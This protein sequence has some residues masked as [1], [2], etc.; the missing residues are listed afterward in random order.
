MELFADTLLK[1]VPSKTRLLCIVQSNYQVVEWFHPQSALST[2]L[3]EHCL[4]C[5]I[6]FC[7]NQQQ[8]AVS[9]L[10]LFI[11]IECVFDIN[12][13]TQRSQALEKSPKHCILVG[14]YLSNMYIACYLMFPDVII[15]IT[16]FAGT[17]FLQFH[18]C[19]AVV[20]CSTY[21]VMLVPIH[22]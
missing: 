3:I 2:F 21:Y 7:F 8:T 1:V 5:E 19:Q 10:L 11:F 20:R 18:G 13:G 12:T 4:L 15:A 16:H 22:D 14:T 9:I 6:H 17:Y